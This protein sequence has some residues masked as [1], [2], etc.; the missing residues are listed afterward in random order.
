[1]IEPCGL[2]ATL[3]STVMNGCNNGGIMSEV[4]Y[5]SNLMNIW[6]SIRATGI[7]CSFEPVTVIIIFFKDRAM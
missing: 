3:I 1:M 2:S 6:L 4:M 5:T 7:Q